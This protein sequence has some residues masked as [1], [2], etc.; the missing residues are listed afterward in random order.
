MHYL[1]NAATTRVLPAVADA[2]DKALRTLFANPASLYAPGADSEAAVNRARAQVAQS[3]GCAAGEIRFTGSGTEANNLALFGACHTR[4][5]WARHIVVTGYE[6]ASV[7]NACAS[8]AASGWSV[9]VVAPGADGIVSLGALVDAVTDE[10]ALVTAMHVNNE[11]GAV[12]D[13]AK[14]A[15]QVKGKNSRTAV[16]VDGVQAWGKVPV[17]LAH[18]KID[19][20]AVSGHK[21]HA[22]KGVG[23]LYLRKGYHILP[24][25]FGGHQEQG[26]RPGTEN[27]AYLVALGKAAALVQQDK[28]DPAPLRAQLLA[29]LAQ[30]PETLKNSP[31]SAYPGIVNFSVSGVKSQPLLNFLAEREVYVSS[32]SACDKGEPSHTLTAMGLSRERIDC[33]LRVSFSTENTPG[34]VDALLDGVRAGAAALARV[35]R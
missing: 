16:H 14:L 3:L 28:F 31:D 4:E 20:Y 25:L 21:I 30:L 13:V 12:L 18:T 8:L 19:S 6:H 7:Q 32:G 24:V 22:P 29:G 27:I 35:R 15:E 11:T 2:A 5:K 26:F 33:A 9:T 34:D 10:T 17:A 23:A 1:D